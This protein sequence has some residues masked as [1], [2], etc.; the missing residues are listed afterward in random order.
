MQNYPLLD[1]INCTADC[2][3]KAKLFFDSFKDNYV[4]VNRHTY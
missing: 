3:T 4:C 1:S 2:F